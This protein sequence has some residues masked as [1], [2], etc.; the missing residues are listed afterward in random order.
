MKMD[1]P[2]ND[3]HTE[4][5]QY[6][7]R[8]RRSG[9]TNMYGAT[10]YLMRQFGLTYKEAGEILAEWMENYDELNDKYGWQ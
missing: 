5:Y 4:H 7:E 3:K 2:I 9:D 6:L 10:P 1:H 8:L